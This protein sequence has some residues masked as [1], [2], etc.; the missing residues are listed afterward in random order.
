MYE[1]GTHCGPTSKS[2]CIHSIDCKWE[3]HTAEAAC[4]RMVV[5]MGV[6]DKERVTY[7]DRNGLA[8]TLVPKLHV[9]F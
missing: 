4:L 9:H 7:C 1:R 6:T 3:K 2:F 5:D 8:V